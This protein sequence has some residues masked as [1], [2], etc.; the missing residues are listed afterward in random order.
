MEINKN[1]VK[2]LLNSKRI[3]IFIHINPD[4]DCLGSASALKQALVS[5]N[6]TV[7]IFSNLI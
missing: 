1:I 4:G 2:T 7:D 6:K 3:A 5:L